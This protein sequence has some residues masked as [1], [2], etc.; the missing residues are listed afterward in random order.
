MDSNH[1]P[2]DYEPCA[3]CERRRSAATLEQRFPANHASC[4]PRACAGIAGSLPNCRRLVDVVGPP[5]RLSTGPEVC[6]AF[7][8][9]RG[10]FGEPIERLPRAL[11]DDQQVALL[12][13]HRLRCRFARAFGSGSASAAA[14]VGRPLRVPGRR[15]RGRPLIRQSNSEALAAAGSRVVDRSPPASL[16]RLAS[17]RGWLDLSRGDLAGDDGGVF[18]YPV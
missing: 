1:R 15:S 11:G 3:C 16:Q 12:R 17:S 5:L 9:L 2:H 18:A 7:R 4:W 14:R 10:R 13:H 6:A 8:Q